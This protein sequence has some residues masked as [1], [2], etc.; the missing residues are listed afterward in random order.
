MEFFIY[1]GSTS[2]IILSFFES[3]YIVQT[4]KENL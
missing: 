1:A 4:T 2:L 3:K